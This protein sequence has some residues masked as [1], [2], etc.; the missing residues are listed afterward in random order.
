MAKM[1]LQLVKSHLQ[2]A[3][4]E[5]RN[6]FEEYDALWSAFNVMYEGTRSELITNGQ[7]SPSERDIIRHCAKKLDHNKWGQLFE[8][9]TLGNLLSI[10]PIFSERDWLRKA[11]LNTKEFDQLVKTAKRGLSAKA[12]EDE[13]LLIAFVDLLYIVRCNR[14]HGFK[15]PHRK[16]DLEVLNATVPLLRELTTKL[17]TQFGVK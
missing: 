6:S 17:A 9:R 7:K 14:H 15:T 13:E 10:E 11:K 3:K 5:S 16:R 1:D 12:E 4:T 2:R 8:P